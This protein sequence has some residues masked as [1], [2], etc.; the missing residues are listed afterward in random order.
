MAYHC[1]HCHEQIEEGYFTPGSQSPDAGLKFCCVNHRAAEYRERH[2][3][4]SPEETFTENASDTFH[5][6]GPDPI[7][8]RKW[9][10]GA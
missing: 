2:P 4:A 6:I 7:P 8:S 3:D 9:W 10:S 1:D 5:A